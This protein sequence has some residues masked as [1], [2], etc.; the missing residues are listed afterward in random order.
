MRFRWQH[1]FSFLSRS[2]DYVLSLNE[3]LM[4]QQ[5]VPVKNLYKTRKQTHK[6]V[7]FVSRRSMLA[8]PKTLCRFSVHV[9]FT[10]FNQWMKF[11]DFQRHLPKEF[12]NIKKYFMENF[13]F[14]GTERKCCLC[15]IKISFKIVDDSRQQ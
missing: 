1:K 12:F 11:M 15:S 3:C 8:A 10:F 4:M 14:F 5:N 9:Q 7:K 6:Q 13:H 2:T